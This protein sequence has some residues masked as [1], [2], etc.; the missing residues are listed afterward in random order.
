M[1]SVRTLADCNNPIIPEKHQY[2]LRLKIQQLI[3]TFTDDNYGYYPERDGYLIYIQTVDDNIAF[4]ELDMHQTLAEFQFEAVMFCVYSQCFAAVLV[5]NNSFAYEFII[6][7][8]N[9]SLSTLKRLEHQVDQAQMQPGDCY[10][11]SRLR[12]NPKRCS[13]IDLESAML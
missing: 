12:S 6:P 8:E 9:L 5:T 11:S 7:V 1:I 2:L 10:S 4:T 3:D 13:I